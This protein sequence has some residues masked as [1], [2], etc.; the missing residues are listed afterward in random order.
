[1]EPVVVVLVLLAV[2]AIAVAREMRGAVRADDPDDRLRRARRLLAVVTLG[3]PL[4]L[5][6]IVVA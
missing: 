1:M 4:L 6:L 2:W 5:A 3:V